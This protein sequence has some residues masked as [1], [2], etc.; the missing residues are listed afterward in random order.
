MQSLYS[1]IKNPVEA[2]N[3]ARVITTEY[4][5]PNLVVEEVEDIE[6]KVIEQ[7][8]V[9][10]RE[11]EALGETIIKN[12]RT[13][14]ETITVEAL[15][16]SAVMEKEA[17]EKGYNQGTTNGYEDGYKAGQE[18]A[19]K[20]LEAKVNEAM[21]N[22][23]RIV[24]KAEKDYKNYMEDKKSHIE[25]AIFEIAKTLAYKEINKDEWVNSLLYPLLEDFKGEENLIIKTNEIHIDDINSK[26]EEY[27][28]LYNLKG[29]V[30]IIK[31][32]RMNPGN[33]VIE[34]NTGKLEV[35]IDIALKEIEKIFSKEVEATND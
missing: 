30:F 32:M 23:F 33:I 10:I 4:V 26:I 17:Y 13:K 19:L 7:P 18:A 5:N 34:K 22:A 14:A 29:E 15:Q 2:S 12:A 28:S 21:E 8:K 1:V 20:D 16:N 11:Y 31:D 24:E 3:T 9:D 27:K 6:V 35:G 25:Q